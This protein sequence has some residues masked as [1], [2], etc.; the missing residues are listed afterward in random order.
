MAYQYGVN[1][2]MRALALASA[3][4][5]AAMLLGLLALGLNVRAVQR[6]AQSITAIAIPLPKTP[7][8]I[9][10][11]P[12]RDD[13]PSG[14]A[15]PPNIKSKAAPVEAPKPPIVLPKI[16]VTPAAPKA[17]EGRDNSSGATDKAGAGSGAGG[18]GDGT[19]SGGTGRGTGG[20]TRPVWRS[21]AIQDR[22]YPR[23]SSSARRGGEV[24]TR[25]TILPNGR[26]QNCGVTRSSGDAE[27]DATTCRL[28]TERFRFKPATDGAGNA[29]SSEYGWRQSWWLERGR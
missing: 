22:D 11:L 15:A 4:L 20:G 25:F 3:A 24:E 26:V 18:Q 23:S 27:I 29:I 5:V 6:V 13:S 12:K 19:G 17:A 2:K 8:P 7:P 14:R 16:N 9:P 21:G 28:I 1:R 10:A